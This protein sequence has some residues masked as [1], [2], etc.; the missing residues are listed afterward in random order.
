MRTTLKKIYRIT[1]FFGLVFLTACTTQQVIK[2]SNTAT[3]DT[4]TMDVPNEQITDSS[5][6]ANTADS[7]TQ[8]WEVGR[9]AYERELDY[10]TIEAIG[11]YK[12]KRA[13]VEAKYFLDLAYM[14]L[15]YNRDKSIA[16]KDL[17]KSLAWLKLSIKTA[18][19]QAL[20]EIKALQNNLQ[21][22]RQSAHLD[23]ESSITWLPVD[24]RV[25][26]DSL[27][28]DLEKLIQKK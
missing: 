17:D 9:A 28:D 4:T 19:Q 16:V 18:D 20:V 2:P 15:N 7:A 14:D 12:T 27:K 3:M 5:D 6:T 22:M 1:L 23:A 11:E 8:L 26:Y 10:S 24:Q 21:K 25:A 13:L